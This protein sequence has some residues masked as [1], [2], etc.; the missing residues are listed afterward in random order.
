[1]I[2]LLV[3][4][5][6]DEVRQAMVDLLNQHDHHAW[7]VSCAEEVDEFSSVVRPNIYVLDVGLPG[8]D[9]FSL[10]ARIRGAQPRVG[11][12]ML[13]AR[14]QLDA[15]LQGYSHGADVYLPKPVNPA[16]LLAVVAAMGRR[17]QSESTYVFKSIIDSDRL[18]LIGPI[19]K[20]AL[21]QRECLLLN[22][23][24]RAN[25]CLL[26]HWQ[27]MELLDPDDKGLTPE[28]V[29]MCIGQ[30][31]K[32]IRS[33]MGFQQSEVVIKAVRGS[34]YRLLVPLEIQ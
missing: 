25:D 17:I 5:D 8:E 9:G 31:R 6:N 24:T 16:E 19:G 7:G 22:A 3:V 12:I 11:I 23:M 28:S 29:A 32:K 27:V 14:S 15:R 10:A 21:T 18:L 2:S 30:L 1:M 20:Q 4:E 26:E 34:G 33:V 13:T